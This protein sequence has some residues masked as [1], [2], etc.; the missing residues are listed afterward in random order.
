M[1]AVELRYV[2][3]TTVDN[4][5][6]LYPQCTICFARPAVTHGHFHIHLGFNLSLSWPEVRMM[7]AAFKFPS[8]LN[9]CKETVTKECL[10]L[11][12]SISPCTAERP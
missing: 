2:K 4:F 1:A 12:Y 9:S 5:T 3:L 7:L 6:D 8:Q 11:D 10:Q